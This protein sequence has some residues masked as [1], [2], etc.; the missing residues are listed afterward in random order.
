MI[1]I[2]IGLFEEHLVLNKQNSFPFSVLAT[3]KNFA[4][5]AV[6]S[7]RIEY[8]NVKTDGEIKI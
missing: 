8:Q 2:D 3:A 7:S 5:N 4:V 1:Y 6:T